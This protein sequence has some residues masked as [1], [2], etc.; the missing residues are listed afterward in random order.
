MI[1]SINQ[2]VPLSE[3][4]KSLSSHPFGFNLRTQKM[5]ECFRILFGMKRSIHYVRK[6]GNPVIMLKQT[7]N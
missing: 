6:P 7:K 4:P 2:S 3:H 5:V 1:D